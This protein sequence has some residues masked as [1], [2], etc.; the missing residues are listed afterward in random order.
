[1]GPIESRGLYGNLNST[2]ESVYN[3]GAAFSNEIHERPE[4]THKGSN[5]M[6]HV[7]MGM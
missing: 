5:L 3:F 7:R 1:M 2:G 4:R 6:N